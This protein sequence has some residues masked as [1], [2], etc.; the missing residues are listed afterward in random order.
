MLYDAIQIDQLTVHVVDNL[1][2][3]QRSEKIQR[4]PAREHFDIALVRRETRDEM[5][6]KTALAADPRNDVI[7][8]CESRF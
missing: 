3:G 7:C 8:H 4:S 6:C 1:D 5:V 2:L